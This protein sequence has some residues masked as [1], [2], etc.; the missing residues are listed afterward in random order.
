MEIIPPTDGIISGYIGSTTVYCGNG[1]DNVVGE[2]CSVSGFTANTMRILTAIPKQGYTF[3]QWSDASVCGSMMDTP[4][5]PITTGNGNTLTAY[6]SP[7]IAI[8]GNN[9]VCI[10]GLSQ[11]KPF[12]WLLKNKDGSIY[13]QGSSSTPSKGESAEVIA[14]EFSLAMGF[15][16]AS[17]NCIKIGN[18]ML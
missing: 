17:D 8:Q 3:S 16:N 14:F 12:S 11:E 18:R 15:K 6:F 9:L 5:L 13:K 10:T 7:K 1:D 2:Q 4:C